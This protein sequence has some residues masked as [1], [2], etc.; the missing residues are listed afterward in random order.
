LRGCVKYREALDREL[1]D[2]PRTF[3]ELTNPRS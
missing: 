2:A 3:T 1:P